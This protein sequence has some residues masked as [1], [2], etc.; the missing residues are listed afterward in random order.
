MSENSKIEWCDHTFNPWIGCTKVSPGC[1]NCYAET[2]DNFRF[3]KTLGGATKDAPISH[4][5]KGAPRHRTSE[6]NW[7]EP[8]KWNKQAAQFIECRCGYRGSL[9]IQEGPILGPLEGCRSC[10]ALD[11]FT[12]PARP[13]VFCASLADWLDDEVPIEW[14]ADLLDLIRR[15]PNLDWLLLTKRPENWDKRIHEALIVAEGGDPCDVDF[16]VNRD[17]SA[18]ETELGEM[19]ND[20]IGERPPANVWIGTTVE[21]QTRAEQRLPDLLDIPAEVRFLSC[22]PM[23]GPVNLSLRNDRVE[24]PAGIHWVICGGESGEDARP[25]HPDWARSLRD[26]CQAAGVPFLFKQWG[27]WHPTI[28]PG[29]NQFVG[30]DNEF[31]D[32]PMQRIGKKAAGRTLDGLEWNEF[33]KVE[34]SKI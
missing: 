17:G 8:L 18:P 25:M 12:K 7:K 4:W 26:Q 27:E 3:S 9:D 15:T 14:L 19:L 23:C 5:G 31:S 20:W 33:P 2:Q 24:M 32:S 1:V 13:R 29:R 21:D 16:F 11:R 22:E 10:D 34:S 28:D 6:A 30:Y